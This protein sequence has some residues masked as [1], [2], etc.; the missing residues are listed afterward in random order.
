MHSTIGTTSL[1]SL[2]RRFPIGHRRIDRLS[3][4]GESPQNGIGSSTQIPVGG[5]VELDRDETL[6]VV[7]IEMVARELFAILVEIGSA[8]LYPHNGHSIHIGS[9]AIVKTCNGEQTWTGE[10]I[11]GSGSGKGRRASIALEFES[12][13]ILGHRRR[14]GKGL[15][16]GR[17]E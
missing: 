6:R 17:L 1:L 9:S 11:E 16:R 7:E 3:I 8:I 12:N 15:T 4:Q 5:K 13:N 2:D 14:K 10:L